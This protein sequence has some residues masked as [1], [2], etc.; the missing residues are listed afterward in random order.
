MENCRLQIL[1][2]RR[3]QWSDTIF[4]RKLYFIALK[5]VSTP[6]HC[7]PLSILVWHRICILFRRMHGSIYIR[8]ITQQQQRWRL[9]RLLRTAITFRAKRLPLTLII[10][11]QNMW[12][13]I[14][15]GNFFCLLRSSLF[16]CCCCSV[17]LPSRMSTQNYV[18]KGSIHSLV[19]RVLQV[20][21]TRIWK[22]FCVWQNVHFWYFMHIKL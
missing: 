11:Q 3:R 16:Y 6:A 20:A 22:C 5:V 15:L 21:A 1:R 10:Y 2:F 7:R 18:M 9:F 12:R 19:P 8:S 17:N 13:T 14:F 4:G